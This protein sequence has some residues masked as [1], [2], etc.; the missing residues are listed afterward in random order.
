MG[1]IKLEVNGQ[2]L[3]PPRVPTKR[4]GEL[5]FLRIPDTQVD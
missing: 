3:R 4:A 2:L 5:L 1:G